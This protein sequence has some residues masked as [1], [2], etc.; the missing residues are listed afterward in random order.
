MR[1]LRGL[2]SQRLACGCLA[3]I[4]ETYAATTVAIVDARGELCT[5]AAH[6]PGELVDQPEFDRAALGSGS[7]P[8]AREPEQLAVAPTLGLTRQQRTSTTCRN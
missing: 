8:Q 4:Y 3:G 6:R 2:G 7:L 5:L 1:L